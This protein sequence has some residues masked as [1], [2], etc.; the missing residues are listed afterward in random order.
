MK[1]FFLL[2]LLAGCGKKTVWSYP[3]VPKNQ[4]SPE[5][6]AM[7]EEELNRI[8][9]D[10]AEIEVDKDVKHLPV[11]VAPLP[12]GV[13]GRCQYGEQNRGAYIVLSPSLFTSIYEYPAS[14]SHLYEKE[15]VRVLIHE[16]GHCYFYRQHEPQTFLE[17]PGNL[18]ELRSEVGA[19]IFDRIPRSLM[20]AESTYRMPKALRKYYISEIAKKA[21]LTDPV[22]LSEFTEFQFVHS[23]T[24]PEIHDHP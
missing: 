23:E 5:T 12:F 22:I 8:Q 20:P 6:K 18:F 21:K 16:I 1:F 10:L 14:D 7:I 11:V 15:F 3:P 9:D 19:V 13:V 24:S 4:A 2:M 17:S